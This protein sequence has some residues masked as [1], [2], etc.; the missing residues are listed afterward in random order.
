M[1]PARGERGKIREWGHKSEKQR[2]TYNF[3]VWMNR[4]HPHCGGGNG[5]GW[6]QAVQMEHQ[7]TE[8]TGHHAAMAGA[9]GEK[10]QRSLMEH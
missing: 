3:S 8:I 7:R 6:L 2:S 1:R 5:E 10:V 4:A 9:P